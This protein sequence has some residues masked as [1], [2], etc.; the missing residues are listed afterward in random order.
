[1]FN[2]QLEFKYLQ[3]CKNIHE[4]YY[5]FIKLHISIIYSFVEIYEIDFYKI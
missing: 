5:G 2:K 1:M 3:M 4:N